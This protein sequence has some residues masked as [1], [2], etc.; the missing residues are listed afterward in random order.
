MGPRRMDGAVAG[1]QMGPRP[2]GPGVQRSGVAA[3]PGMGQ[4][5][6]GAVPP[7][8]PLAS[9]PQMRPSQ[10]VRRPMQPAGGRQLGHQAS[11]QLAAPAQSQRPAQSQ[12][13]A[14]GQQSVQG[15]KMNSG[16]WIV[17]QFVIGLAVIAGVAAAVVWLWVKYYQ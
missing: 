11:V 3:R 4:R 8:R 7:P 16:V 14:Q 2:A 9:N 13:P 1:G 17:L 10:P 5:P 6:A 15:Q 12:K